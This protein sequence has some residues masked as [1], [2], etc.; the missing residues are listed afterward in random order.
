[1]THYHSRNSAEIGIVVFILSFMC[2]KNNLLTAPFVYG[3]M[4]VCCECCV[5]SDRG[6]CDEP[7]TRPEES[8]RLWCVVVCDLESSRMRSPWPTGGC[9][10]KNKQTK[11][12]SYI[13][14]AILWHWQK[15]DFSRSFCTSPREVSER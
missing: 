4:F 15:P 14:I 7:I 11:E 9:C 10:P 6:I 5:L 1:M 13:L 3:W 12:C 2:G 8:Y